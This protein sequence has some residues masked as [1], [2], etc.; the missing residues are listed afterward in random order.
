MS[1][2]MTRRN[3]ELVLLIAAA[4]VA[5]L[6]FGLAILSDGTSLDPAALVV[7]AGLLASFIAAH[8]AIRRLAPA[9]DPALLPIVYMLSNIGITFVMRLAPAAANRQVMWLFLSIAAM[10]VVLALVPSLSKLTQYKYTLMICGLILLLLPAFVGTEIYGSRIWLT[11]MGYSFQPGEVAKV[12]IVLF[13]AAYLA[14]NREMLSV[15]SRRLLGIRFPDPRALAPLL[16]MWALSLVV[17]VFER[18][19]G[20]AL[21]VLGIFLVMVYICTGRLVYVIGGTVLALA[22]FAAAWYFF[23]HVQVRVNIWLDPFAD[24]NGSGFQIVQALYSLADGGLFGTGIGRGMP[25]FIPVVASDFI[26]V[27][28]A[29]ELGLLGASAVLILYLLFAVRGLTVAA[30]ARSDIDAFCAAGLTVAIA[31]QAFVIVGGTTRLI[32]LTGVTLPFVSQGGTS[33]LTSFVIVAL[34]LRAGDNGTGLETEMVG[35]PSLEGGVLGR[36]TLGKRLTFFMGTLACLFALLVVNLSWYMVV[37][38][39]TLQSDPAN[40]HSILRNANA[41]FG[42]IVSADGVVLAQSYQD[43]SGNWQRDYPQGPLAAHIVGYRSRSYGMAGIEARFN[44]TLAGRQGF[45]SLNDA[46]MAYAGREQLGNDIHL[47]LDSRINRSVDEILAG[48]TGAAVVLD[49]QSGELLAL[50]SLPGYDPNQID[51]LLANIGDDGTGLG[52]GSSQLYNR[53]SQALYAPGSSFKTVTLFA[54]LSEGVATLSDVYDAPPRLEIGGADVTNYNLNDYGQVD[55]QRGFELSSNTVFG[56]LAVQ[57]GPNRLVG[58]AERLGFNK[59]LDSDFDV[60]ASLMSKPS[61]MSEW[62]TAWAGI[63]QPVGQHAS[64]AGPQVTVVQMAMVAACVANDGELMRP[65]V[66]S[67][68]TTAEG[69]MVSQS[70]PQSLGQVMSADVAGQMQTAMRGVV[71]QGTGTAAYI[72][73]YLVAGKTGTAQTGNEQ[74]DSWFIGW[75]EIDGHSYVV[76]VVLEQRETGAAV[77]Y[78]RRIFEALIRVYG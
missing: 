65:Y 15:A 56:Q 30:R 36:L 71:L 74:A 48:Q 45:T 28:I 44:E 32:P 49:A 26:F 34:L 64:P 52:G 41:P 5:F 37:Q 3:T 46:L 47:T 54:A 57:I 67:Y 13:L 35:I 23:G 39:D 40:S 69:F 53:A 63:G 4:P 22:G 31:L 68:V 50:T 11:F 7:P 25:E 59:P 2:A 24:R 73:G 42:S 19:L 66:V 78:A 76:A 16:V 27:A 61:E 33:L 29:E 58:A 20:S 6:L 62:E 43:E 12:L 18:D 8:L 70:S 9:A 10:V 51:S 38:A 60:A 75:V 72:D 77:P 14:D 55:L 21:L 17:M 1:S